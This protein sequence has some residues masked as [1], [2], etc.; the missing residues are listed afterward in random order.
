MKQLFPFIVNE[1]LTTLIKS[2]SEMTKYGYIDNGVDI[3]D[4]S[5]G[6]CG[7]FPL[8]Y[9]RTDII[10]HVN[11]EMQSM[12]F[13]PGDFATTNK[14]VNELSEKLY[15]LSG[16]FYS[17]YSLS[18]SDSIEGAAKLVHMYHYKNKHKNKIIGFKNAYHGST[19]MS[20]SVGGFKSMTGYFGRH[21]ECIDIEY[22]EIEQHIDDNTKAVF[23]ETISWGNNLQPLDV[24]Y[25]KRLRQLCDMHDVLLV[26][27]DIA[28]C[29]GKAGS[30]LGYTKLDIQPDIFTL[31]KGISGGYYPLAVVLC[32]Q[33]VA[34]VVK[35]QF[36]L[37]GFTYSFPMPGII[38]TLKYLSVLEEE[39]ILSHHN[40]TRQMGI[41]VMERL[42]SK[43]LIS[44]YNNFGTCFSAAPSNV[45]EDATLRDTV[46][47]KAGLH[48]GVWNNN[49]SHILIMSPIIPDTEYFESLEY[50]LTQ[51]LSQ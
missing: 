39:Q 37:H 23:I 4:L 35:P 48:M 16:G 32:N 27:D 6:S 11:K 50:K 49:K 22:H 9:K 7:S 20:T 19:Y 30:I 38:S 25:Y 5:L 26:V 28:F 17:L 3:L 40:Q 51:A 33:K 21:P 1:P 41:D 14:F 29:G 47:Y 31:G 24:D 44:S 12:P 18:G 36:L 13:C 34:D 15:N 2:V 46:F 42:K 43:S 8:G 45:I 10:E